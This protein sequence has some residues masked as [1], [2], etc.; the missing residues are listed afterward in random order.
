M[1]S[2]LVRPK[3]LQLMCSAHPFAIS[4]AQSGSKTIGSR[5]IASPW[6]PLAGEDGSSVDD[7]QSSDATAS[8]GAGSMRNARMAAFA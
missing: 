7:D 6:Y 1:L 3:W 5:A 4:V 8:S 2:I